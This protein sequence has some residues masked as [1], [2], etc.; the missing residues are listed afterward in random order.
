MKE[1]IL[2]VFNN[3]SFLIASTCNLI[4]ICFL[5]MQAASL[6]GEAHIKVFIEN[7]EKQYINTISDNLEKY[8]HARL[9]W[10]DEDRFHK[11]SLIDA[12]PEVKDMSIK[13]FNENILDS[14]IWEPYLTLFFKE[15]DNYINA[16]KD[17]K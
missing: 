9:E 6:K 4:G 15:A 3:K 1:V 13:L 12:L 17:L 11:Q 10:T 8:K 5:E 2:E 16:T 7:K 14:S